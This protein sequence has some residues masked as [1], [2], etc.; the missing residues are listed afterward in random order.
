MAAEWM[1]YG[2]NG[3]TGELIARKAAA[4]GLKP[5]LAGRNRAKVEALAAELGLAS[6]V[7]SLEGDA[8]DKALAG[9]SLVLHC[10]GP[11]VITSPPMARA[12][13]RT[14]THYLDITGEIPVFAALYSMSD[15]A[16]AAGVMLLPGTGFDIVPTDCMAVRLKNKLP[17]A[18]HL[19]LAFV[20][21]G[22]LSSGTAYSS[23]IQLPNG[24]KIRENGELKAVPLFSRAKQFEILRKTTTLY[25]VPWGDVFTSYISTG[26]PNTIV[27]TGVA[28][29]QVRMFKVVRPFVG[30]LSVP[31][32]Q[33]ALG[34]VIRRRA[35]GPDEATR[36]NGRSF[37]WGRAADASGRSVEDCLV[38]A[39][40]YQFTVHS[41]LLA[42]AR[43]LKGKAVPGF[44][45]PGS[46]FGEDFVLQ[47]PGSRYSPGLKAV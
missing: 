17:S 27:Y 2:A 16:A 26:I 33:K 12:C 46:L 19:E 18:D 15:E 42:V 44:Q 25:A 9:M 40:G 1:I 23:L 35:R 34:N 36:T 13:L 37:V 32:I 41:A 45:T 10:A 28:P 20:G 4:D 5:V 14:K 43:I 6:K 47:V 29:S 21:L 3:Y 39:D 7:F 31:F 30:M 24:G 38:T 8:P 22:S 11:F